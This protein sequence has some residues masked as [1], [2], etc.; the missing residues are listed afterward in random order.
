MAIALV[1]SR[2]NAGGGAGTVPRCLLNSA[3]A[4]GDLLVGWLFILDTVASIS[5]PTG[6]T[7]QTSKQHSVS[8]MSVFLSTQI[9][10]GGETSFD[11]GYAGS[12]NWET[13]GAEFS[14]A[15]QASVLD[16]AATPKEANGVTSLQANS[17]LPGAANELFLINNGV[18]AGEGGAAAIDSTFTSL[19]DAVWHSRMF[20]AYKIKTDALAEAPTVSWATGAQNAV[21]VMAVVK[22]FTAAGGGE[23]HLPRGVGRG[24]TRGVH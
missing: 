24:L 13:E 10:A 6:G 22:Q 23:R 14:G 16:L 15:A 9:A 3:A 11:F 17:T 7:I 20:P 1:Q 12:A 18:I 2:P 8:T 21:D 5:A 4:S 19:R